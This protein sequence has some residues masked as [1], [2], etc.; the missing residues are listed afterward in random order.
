MTRNYSISA[1]IAVYNTER[2]IAEAIESVLHQ[3]YP[4][5][6]IIIFNDGST[7][8][9]GAIVK[10]FSD[11]VRYIEGK[12]IG[13][14][15]AR[16]YLLTQ[17]KGDWIAFHDADDIWMPQKLEKQT[18]FLNQ[19][20]KMDACLGLAL[21]F[22]ETGHTLPSNYK[23]SILDEP[24]AQFY[25]PNMLVKKEVFNVVG[26]FTC[27]GKPTGVDSEWF[28]R[29]KDANIK[30]GIVNEVLYKRRWHD[31]NLSHTLVFEK[32]ML[33]ILRRSIHRKKQN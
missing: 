7:D 30:I 9:T 32:T 23:K 22:L 25:L 21:Q 13:V 18:A 29:A 3:T 4:P 6:E 10:T 14:T 5:M 16:N 27:Y 15:A 19:N 31:K 8:N 1:L 11:R 24:S 26:N 12:K 20:P 33:D 2:F 17:A 28:A